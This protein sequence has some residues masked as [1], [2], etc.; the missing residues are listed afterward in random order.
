MMGKIV[1]LFCS[2][3]RQG[4][5]ISAVIGSGHGTL[6]GD[7]VSLGLESQPHQCVSQYRQWQASQL[8]E[9]IV[10]LHRS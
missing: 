6:V 1:T 8:P 3:E 9:E 5:L 7:I 2:G 10:R 4:V